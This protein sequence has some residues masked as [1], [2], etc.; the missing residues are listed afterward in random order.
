[1]PVLYA[2]TNEKFCQNIV[3][4][5]IVGGKVTLIVVVNST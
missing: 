1:M 3:G 2:L 5:H 4:V